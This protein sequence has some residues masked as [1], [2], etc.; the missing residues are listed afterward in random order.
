MS[1]L[2]YIRFERMGMVSDAFVLFP[3]YVGHRDMVLAMPNHKA[4]SAGFA[5]LTKTDIGNPMFK[6]EGKSIGLGLNSKP[7]DSRLLNE[8]FYSET[9]L[10]MF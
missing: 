8:Q 6:C 5:Y 9:D 7:E 1:K 4:I 3:E 10:S 2:K